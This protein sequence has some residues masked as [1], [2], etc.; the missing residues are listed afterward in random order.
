[1]KKK[2]SE[3]IR[4]NKIESLRNYYQDKDFTIIGLND[5]QGVNT[6]TLFRKGLLEYLA[7]SLKS[8]GLDPKVI[9]A[10]S[11]MFN[12]TEHINYLL[13]SNLSLEE[14]KD[15]QVYGMVSALEK[16]MQ[17]FHMPKFV[18]KVGHISRILYRPKKGDDEIFFT[19][20]LKQ[21]KEPIVLYSCG[22][23]DLMREGWNNPFSIGKD[24]KNRDKNF[25]YDYAYY[26]LE[27][28][29]AVQR[30]IGRVEGNIN[31][32]LTIND[33]ADIF[34]LG[35]YIPKSMQCDGMEVFNDAIAR[36]NE[37]LQELCAKYKL[38]YIDTEKGGK[39]YN[40]SNINFHVSTAGHNALANEIIDQLYDKKI[41]NGEHA[42][43]N[44]EN[45]FKIQNHKSW[46]LLI[47]LK[48]DL[49]KVEEESV[50]SFGRQ[51]EVYVKM[52]KEL[53]RQIGVVEKVAEKIDVKTVVK[54]R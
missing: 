37:Y 10:F 23:N 27:D 17:D 26:K 31:N 39:E 35:L 22:A 21:A 51:K 54:G 8:D 20:T 6:T 49:K 7:D 25:N 24:Y 28:P 5:S 33:S 48:H 36:Y 14:I 32:I 52:K 11:L 46:D 12:K 1:M 43:L 44:I 34:S 30:V 47:N 19:D 16:A 42:N 3:E 13:E 50:G 40:K 38:T 45:Q 41:W 9:N 4:D 18:G 29:K 15:L 53:E 2:Y